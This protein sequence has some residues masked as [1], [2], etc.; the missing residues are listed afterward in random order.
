[1]IER[2]DQDSGA[3]EAF[4]CESQIFP[5][6]SGYG[7]GATRGGSYTDLELN[8]D[9]SHWTGFWSNHDVAGLVAYQLDI[10]GNRSGTNT[11]VEVAV[12]LGVQGI[13]LALGG[14]HLKYEIDMKNYARDSW[15][16]I[17]R[18]RG[19]PVNWFVARSERQNH[20][21]SPPAGTYEELD[22]FFSTNAGSDDCCQVRVRFWIEANIDK[23]AGVTV[24][25]DVWM[26]YLRVRVETVSPPHDPK[27][28]R[29][30]Y[31]SGDDMSVDF[32]PHVGGYVSD[33]DSFV[34]GNH[35]SDVLG[36]VATSF[37]W[38]RFDEL[39]GFN[40]LDRRG[41]TM[42]QTLR[43]VAMIH[44]GYWW[45]S[46]ENKKRIA[47]YMPRLDEIQTY[48]DFV[49][50]D[51][52]SDIDDIDG[53]EETQK[54][55]VG[56][57]S[58][59]EVSQT[60]NT[61]MKFI[62]SHQPEDEYHIIKQ[63]VNRTD[64]DGI[65]E[66]EFSL[67]G[68][69]WDSGTARP[70]TVEFC[71]ANDDVVL[72]L[73]WD[74]DGGGN[75]ILEVEDNDGTTEYAAEILPS[76][77]YMVFKLIFNADGSFDLYNKD[78]AEATFTLRHS[79][80]IDTRNF[81]HVNWKC[82][83]PTGGTNAEFHVGHITYWSRRLV[84]EYDEDYAGLKDGCRAVH[85]TNWYPHIGLAHDYDGIDVLDHIEAIG[86]YM[87]LH[88]Y[89][90]EDD[91][92]F[93]LRRDIGRFEVGDVIE[94]DIYQNENNDASNAFF[95]LNFDAA[96]A[97]ED[98]DNGFKFPKDASDG[99]RCGDTNTSGV[100]SVQTWHHFKIKKSASNKAKTWL[101]GNYLGDHSHDDDLSTVISM[102][103]LG[104]GAG[105]NIIDF[106]ITNWK[107]SWTS[108]I[109]GKTINVQP[110]S[111]ITKKA[112]SI[113]KVTIRTKARRITDD[114]AGEEDDP[115]PVIVPNLDDD[116]EKTLGNPSSPYGAYLVD[117]V[118]QER[119]SVRERAL[120]FLRQNSED[121]FN[122][123]C[124]PLDD[125]ETQIHH[126]GQYRDVQIEGTWYRS[127]IIRRVD[128]KYNAE[129]REGIYILDLGKSGT[130][131]YEKRQRAEQDRDDNINEI[132]RDRISNA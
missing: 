79:G 44:G 61:N 124:V 12:G 29:I 18:S 82:G 64:C 77:D 78:S 131:E 119:A 45:W 118:L 2:Y 107:F 57:T 102:Y 122:I 126:V 66:F 93:M 94:F 106:Y 67:Q 27:V 114:D 9:D 62:S 21:I 54:N 129:S 3:D 112:T 74:D 20:V 110:F 69:N 70:F 36:D 46:F 26:R 22:D 123:Q 10:T 88:F 116:Y 81:N 34:V 41:S 120:S 75:L 48:I 63:T 17:Y 132:R 65:S 51:D 91:A 108:K 111:K 89:T 6:Q 19:Y 104:A 1:V 128:W 80:E 76:V 43:D 113:S 95:T 55:G 84:G 105:A 125:Q 52:G 72:K 14:G 16:V 13:S 68:T 7:F 71:N 39:Y 40:F 15:E 97:L 87:A 25:L 59:V 38:G 73:W 58:T 37:D 5:S 8:D 53:F 33:G 24:S 28:G 92:G 4:E 121:A 47:W 117:D 103:G 23:G 101:D 109:H 90:D 32:F 60:N 49:D 100:L 56:S 42:I 30:S 127:Q 35:V 83:P 98:A 130:P 85:W 31:I 115:M 96:A 50:R 86:D 11:K 99:I